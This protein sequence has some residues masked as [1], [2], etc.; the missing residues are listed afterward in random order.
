MDSEIKT[1]FTII[2][3]A[4]LVMIS[5]L[6]VS[7]YFEMQTFNKFSKTKA[8]MRDAIFGELRIFADK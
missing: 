6:F 7:S 5:A 1:M 8:S 3:I 2:I 4:L